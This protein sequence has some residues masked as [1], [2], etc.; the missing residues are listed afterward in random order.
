MSSYQVVVNAVG[1]NG[2]P[3]HSQITTNSAYPS[4]DLVHELHRAHQLGGPSTTF[5]TSVFG[6]DSPPGSNADVVFGGQDNRF[7][8][9]TD[10]YSAFKATYY[11]V[12]TPSGRINMVRFNEVFK[13]KTGI[14][15]ITY[16]G[17][18]NSVFELH[19][20]EI[21][22]TFVEPGENY[23]QAMLR[24]DGHDFQMRG[25]ENGVIADVRKLFQ[26]EENKSE[27]EDIL[28]EDQASWV[29]RYRYGTSTVPERDA[30]E[31]DTVL[32]TSYA[33]VK[34]FYVSLN[35]F[36]LSMELYYSTGKLMHWVRSKLALSGSP[37][38]L[39]HSAH[40]VYGKYSMPNLIF[41]NQ[42]GG[43]GL[44]DQT[45]RY[46]GISHALINLIRKEGER[47][48]A[49]HEVVWCSEIALIAEKMKIDV[50]FCSPDAM[51]GVL[52]KLGAKAKAGDLE[53]DKDEFLSMD[54]NTSKVP[55]YM[56]FRGQVRKQ[57]R[58]GAIVLIVDNMANPI[59]HVD[60]ILDT[61]YCMEMAKVRN[62]LYYPRVVLNLTG[63]ETIA[64]Q[65]REEFFGGEARVK[66]YRTEDVVRKPVYYDPSDGIGVEKFAKQPPSVRPFLVETQEEFDTWTGDFLLMS[67]SIPDNIETKL[68]E[69]TEAIESLDH[70]DSGRKEELVAEVVDYCSSLV[71]DFLFLCGDMVVL[72]DALMRDK[73]F[74][75]RIGSPG[76]MADIL[77]VYEALRNRMIEQG[78]KP[79]KVSGFL[80]VLGTGEL[81]RE[82]LI[83][84][85]INGNGLYT[86]EAIRLK[87]VVALKIRLDIPLS[88]MGA[89]LPACVFQ[90]TLEPGQ[91]CYK[92][93]SIVE[94]DSFTY[95]ATFKAMESKYTDA[96]RDKEGTTNEVW[97]RKIGEWRRRNSLKH[98]ATNTR[99]INLYMDILM[100]KKKFAIAGGNIGKSIFAC[101]Q[102]WE[103]VHVELAQIL[104]PVY[105]DPVI[106]YFNHVGAFAEPRQL[107][108]Q[109]HQID[110]SSHYGNIMLGGYN[111]VMSPDCFG[112]T[113]QFGGI[114][115]P[116]LER[117]NYQED[118]VDSLVLSYLMDFGH[119]WVEGAKIRTVIGA[120]HFPDFSTISGPFNRL[121][122]EGR[123]VACSTIIDFCQQ[124]AESKGIRTEGL[125]PEYLALCSTIQR[126]FLNITIGKFDFSRNV[127]VAGKR[128]LRAGKKLDD[129]PLGDE[130][131]AAVKTRIVLPNVNCL[132]SAQGKTCPSPMGTYEPSKLL[133]DGMQRSSNLF[134]RCA[135]VTHLM[136]E[137]LPDYVEQVPRYADA[138]CK[139]GLGDDGVPTKTASK[140]TVVKDS[141]RRMIGLTRHFIA[142]GI[143]NRFVG[144]EQSMALEKMNCRRQKTLYSPHRLG[145]IP[146]S[147]YCAFN[148]DILTMNKVGVCSLPGLDGRVLIAIISAWAAV[149]RGHVGEFRSMILT[150]SQALMWRVMRAC[151]PLR[152]RVDSVLVEEQDVAP[153]KECL[154]RFLW[155]GALTAEQVE[156][157]PAAKLLPGRSPCYTH[158]VLDMTTPSLLREE[159]LRKSF[160]EEA[161]D[162]EQ[163]P[164]NE[165]ATRLHGM[166]KKGLEP[167]TTVRDSEELLRFASLGENKDLVTGFLNGLPPT[168]QIAFNTPADGKELHEA[169]MHKYGD[170]EAVRSFYERFTT[171]SVKRFVDSYEGCL[172]VGGPGA[173]KSTRV[174]AMI[175]E[176]EKR[177]REQG[178]YG[179][180]ETIP[181][182]VVGLAAGMH[183]VL[184]N[185]RDLGNDCVWVDTL[186]KMFGVRN[187]V[188]RLFRNVDATMEQAR[189]A[190]NGG[191][192]KLK[193]LFVDECELVNKEFEEFFKLLFEE[194]RVK[195]FLIGD[196]NQTCCLFGRG[197][198][199]DGAVSSYTCTNRKYVFDLQFR[200]PDWDYQLSMETILSSGNITDYLTRGVYE[201]GKLGNSVASNVLDDTLERIAGHLFRGEHNPIT[202]GCQNWKVV[203]LCWLEVLRRYKRLESEHGRASE[204]FVL[205][206]SGP[207]FDAKN[208]ALE[209]GEEVSFDQVGLYQGKQST[210]QVDKFRLNS[211][212]QNSSCITTASQQLQKVPKARS[213]NGPGSRRFM[214]GLPLLFAPG[215]VFTS[216][217]KF[218]SAFVPFHL[219]DETEGGLPSMFQPR[220]GCMVEQQSRYQYIGCETILAEIEN[221]FHK[222]G[223]ALDKEQRRGRERGY[224]F[225]NPPEHVYAYVR[226]LQFSV[227]GFPERNNVFMTEME[228]AMYLIPSFVVLDSFCVGATIEQFVYVQIAIPKRSCNGV[229]EYIPSYKP[230]KKTLEEQE[231]VLG[232]VA[233]CTELARSMRVAMTRVRNVGDCKVLDL[234]ANAFRFWG[235]FFQTNRAP[236]MFA[237]YADQGH[238][239]HY[240]LFEGMRHS[241][242]LGHSKFRRSLSLADEERLDYQALLYLAQVNS[243]RVSDL[244][245]MPEEACQYRPNNWSFPSGRPFSGEPADN[246]F[247]A[248]NKDMDKTCEYH[249]GTHMAVVEDST[250][251]TEELDI[252]SQ[253]SYFVSA[254]QLGMAMG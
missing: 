106:M 66:E 166:I 244:V 18:G 73:R 250:S 50:T 16:P 205:I 13:E 119:V 161:I 94:S 3:I 217:H 75:E 115:N 81:V 184:K 103:N 227:E 101:F 49:I 152:V 20:Q 82:I 10:F 114:R 29:V 157:E 158:E 41:K 111:K 127:R 237:E 38:S 7:I 223:G 220:G 77:Y 14:Y 233:T 245:S 225:R 19:A 129:L 189:K 109:L 221:P 83:T 133:R 144:N 177:E 120:I 32:L 136:L 71:T 213:W 198:D 63:N 90:L 185:Y 1:P 4:V 183:S 151:R 207:E 238:S 74:A 216:T 254:N 34:D 30:L 5:L 27:I 236:F 42:P 138:Y 163:L 39:Y 108:R 226:I 92:T 121:E 43:E 48:R 123:F 67:S 146:D 171:W 53:M 93:D 153:V 148:A 182:P 159:L 26:A 247:V 102:S 253:E 97:Q 241:I 228:A 190:G 23:F 86:P 12:A 218:V 117:I 84:T 243:I 194:Y 139:P 95:K 68:R 219:R 122:R 64:G 17:G 239:D 195:F 143:G 196:P 188:S 242:L 141:M 79:P 107:P 230:L 204:H 154:E 156:E 176:L 201:D 124:V 69:A 112:H 193:Y 89:V 87:K 187:E 132:Y 222:K 140:S 135:E 137:A 203:G 175:K 162:P 192:G 55:I 6:I 8:S 47:P 51:D 116:K 240:S 2:T 191:A 99:S 234:E 46:N 35:C 85:N 165:C 231:R 80:P 36:M 167:W 98:V 37:A 28:K 178:Q 100:S 91:L 214:V 11:E 104:Y 229:T 76:P 155:E 202:I 70:T 105:Q 249:Q 252:G 145:K 61:E 52:E 110:L 199:M 160:Q 54:I 44:E 211:T 170:N 130:V 88:F 96:L 173:G 149:Y 62:R 246:T 174:K 21:A 179:P 197:F 72:S 181:H 134:E 60:P 251:D 248:Y 125:A 142:N 15:F 22:P 147:T 128:W 215:H 186:H 9:M 232:D 210:F 200:N 150:I 24:F 172:I 118:P 126:D 168:Q 31:T 131:R 33:K 78:S 65:S 113:A 212:H 235:F 180:D 164:E 25:A 57:P 209:V 40:S 206:R 224:Q 45:T 169:L 208:I 58:F 56:Y 59:R